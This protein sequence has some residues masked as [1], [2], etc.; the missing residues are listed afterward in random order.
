MLWS[1]RILS[2]LETLNIMSSSTVPGPSTSEL[3]DILRRCPNLRQFAMSSEI[4]VSDTILS[5]VEIAHLPALKSFQLSV[6][7]AETFNEIISSVRIPKCTRFDLMCH[8]AEGIFFNEAGHFTSALLSA[9]QFV[10]EI[11]LS[12]S[13]FTPTLSERHTED[14]PGPGIKV[15]LH[16]NSAWKILASLID[17]AGPVPWP[18]IDATIA[19]FH[20]FPSLRVVN[21]LNKMPS[22]TR[23]VLRGDSDEFITHLSHPILNE[24]N[25]EWALPNLKELQLQLCFHNN[26]ALLLDLAKQRK[27]GADRNRGDGVRLG[28]STKLEMIHILLPLSFHRIADTK[29]FY[30]ALRAPKGEDGAQ[31]G[32]PTKPETT[33]VPLPLSV[34]RMADTE[35]FYPALLALKGEDGAR[36]LID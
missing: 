18:P 21:I 23:L 24:G 5:K 22:V 14:D 34:H 27:K 11:K 33:L 16:S 36:N 19:T 35:S 2:R 13:V 32:L 17:A 31:L 15:T 30:L 10:P 29:S 7:D 3:I 9:I 6:R 1:S 12:L 28:L 8:A 25:Y 20:S 26:L 4:R